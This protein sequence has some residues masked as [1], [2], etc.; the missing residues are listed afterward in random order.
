MMGNTQR[1]GMDGTCTDKPHSGATCLKVSYK[2]GDGWAG[3]IWQDPPGDW[4]DLPGG[5]DLSGASKLT[6]WARGANGGEKVIF[7]FGILKGKKYNDSA[8]GETPVTLTNDWK[9]FTIDLTGKDLSCIKSGFHWTVAGQGKPVVFYL[10]DVQY[11][12]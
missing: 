6:I 3:V 2:A 5:Y 1:V 4:G 12:K 10:D 8:G 7:G 11:E 9:Q